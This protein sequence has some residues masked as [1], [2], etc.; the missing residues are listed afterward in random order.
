MGETVRTFIAIEMPPEVRDYLEG[1]QELLRG[2]G[3]DVRWMRTDLIHLTLVF[4]GEVAVEELAA[5]GSAV[6]QAVAGFEPVTLRAGGAGQFPPRGRPRVVWIGID[7]PTGSLVRLQKAVADAT[8]PFA[9]KVENRAYRPHLT[10]GRV[11]GG[12][13]LHRLSAAVAE[14]ADQQ[15]PEFEADEIIVMQSTLSPQ[16]PTY[17]PLSRIALGD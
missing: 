5:L 15:G 11:R 4:L 14:M 16:G 1:C 2:T 9:E 3:G 17:L 6:E 8:A 13:D 7:E 12:R 10:L